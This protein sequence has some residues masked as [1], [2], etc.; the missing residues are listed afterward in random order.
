[1]NHTVG[2]NDTLYKRYGIKGSEHTPETEAL[3]EVIR[4]FE[5]RV[6]P[7]SEAGLRSVATRLLAAIDKAM[8]EDDDLP[9]GIDGTLI[10]DLR[11]AITVVPES[12]AGL[13]EM[14]EMVDRECSLM[15]PTDTLAD[16]VQR[17]VH[18]AL[19]QREAAGSLIAALYAYDRLPTDQGM[20][21]QKADAGQEVWYRRSMLGA[22]LAPREEKQ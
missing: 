17:I 1:M 2:E 14:L 8:A 6:T 5:S 13:R 15:A 9:D 3:C 22:A 18:S 4:D 21:H 19:A 12:E 16:R 20:R 11:D 10:D 7:A